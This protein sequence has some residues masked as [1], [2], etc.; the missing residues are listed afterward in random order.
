MSGLPVIVEAPSSQS[1]CKACTYAGDGSDP[2]IQQGSMRVGIPGHAAGGITVYHWCKPECFAKHC[3]RVDKAPTGRAKCR[4]DGTLIPK[5][6]VRLL[7]GYKKDSTLYKVENADRTIVPQ[8]RT[9]VGS[10][11]LT[12]H[13]L[14]ELSS[15]ERLLAEKHILGAAQK[16][17]RAAEAPA[18]KARQTAKKTTTAKTPTKKTQT[19]AAKR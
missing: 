2:I 11:K 8:L 15:D 17:K 1:K 12:I 18:P 10:A 19:H 7:V 4:G 6:G 16:P 13:G 5:G 3:I 9:L 14:S